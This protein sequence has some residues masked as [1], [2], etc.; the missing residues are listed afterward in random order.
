MPHRNKIFQRNVT[1]VNIKQASTSVRYV[2]FGNVGRTARGLLKKIL[3]MPLKLAE[4]LG[5][6]LTNPQGFYIL[7]GTTGHARM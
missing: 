6:G 4:L 5:R 1:P 2:T 7:F 3:Q